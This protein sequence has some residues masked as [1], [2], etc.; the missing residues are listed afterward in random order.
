V[1]GI[2]LVL[3]LGLVPW[4]GPALALQL[5]LCAPFTYWVIDPTLKTPII[6]IPYLSRCPLAAGSG[7]NA[8][9]LGDADKKTLGIPEA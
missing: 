3:R 8:H 9:S 1:L 2:G 4:L 5:G 7:W 6:S